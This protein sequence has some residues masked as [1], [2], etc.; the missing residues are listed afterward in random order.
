VQAR[1]ALFDVYGDHLR[2]RDGQAHVA[3]LI[4]L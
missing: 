4:Q 1:S 3:A 2:E